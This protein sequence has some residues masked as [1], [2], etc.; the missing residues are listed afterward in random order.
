M[1]CLDV[2]DFVIIFLHS[3]YNF[4][5]ELAFLV[6]VL[7]R[8]DD[9]SVPQT[10]AVGHAASMETA[11]IKHLMRKDMSSVETVNTALFRY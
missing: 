9:G 8:I 7:V 10:S 11:I 6:I 3:I 5:N 2:Q 4:H 1:V